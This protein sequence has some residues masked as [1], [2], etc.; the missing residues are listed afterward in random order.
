M[1]SDD[2]HHASARSRSHGESYKELAIYFTQ[3]EKRREERGK[4]RTN[5][6]TLHKGGKGE[7][8]QGR[9]IKLPKLPL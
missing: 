9:L 1:T 7:G 4:A 5:Q 6:I 8:R 3:S 2:G